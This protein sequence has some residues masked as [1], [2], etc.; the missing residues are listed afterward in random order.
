[1]YG[2]TEYYKAAHNPRYY[3]V[4]KGAKGLS[5]S[6]LGQKYPIKQVNPTK[7]KGLSG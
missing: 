1:M 7:Q 2:Y 4:L 6:P 5:S 3:R